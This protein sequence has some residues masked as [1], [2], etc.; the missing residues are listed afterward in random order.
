MIKIADELM[1]KLRKIKALADDAKDENEGI[2]A[3][4]AYQRLLTRNGLNEQDVD[5]ELDDDGEEVNRVD[6]LTRSRVDVWKIMLHNTIGQHFRC[7]TLSDKS[8]KWAG[9]YIKKV[10][11]LKY[12]GM[13]QDPYLASQAFNTA[14]KVASALWNQKKHDFIRRGNDSPAAKNTYMS[15]F[16]EGM[17]KAFMEQEAREELGLILV[18]DK[19]V[20]ES[21]S[22]LKTFTRRFSMDSNRGIRDAGYT[23][24]NNFG[25]GNALPKGNIAMAIR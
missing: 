7:M 21:L 23:D 16:N 22:G 14:V 19:R 2:A 20:D 15:G 17:Q 4:L 8:R 3:L 24:G 25:R 11:T 12:V 1:D 18:R 9:S 6:C 13:G 10:E 5:V